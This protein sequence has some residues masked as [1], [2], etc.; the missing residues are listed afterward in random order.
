[1]SKLR[2]TKSK[3]NI[4]YMVLADLQHVLQSAEREQ[5]MLLAEKQRD[6]SFRS[7]GDVSGDKY[8]INDERD[9][10]MVEKRL[11]FLFQCDLLPGLQGKVLEAK[12]QRDFF[13]P[14]V[15]AQHWKVGAWVLTMLLNGGML[16][17]ITLFALRQSTA[18]QSAWFQSF[19]IWLVSEVF[20]VSTMSMMATHV[21]IPSL[22]MGDV[23]RLKTKIVEQIN[24][25][26][27]KLRT[28][29]DDSMDS[30]GNALEGNGFNAAKYLYVSHRLASMYPQLKVAKVVQSY[31]TVW[32]RQSY[33]VR[34]FTIRRI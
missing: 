6:A 14:R 15:I 34:T 25:F 24:T 2:L 4:K 10:D 1:M 32:P 7:K 18:R 5:A 3:G 8:L 22:V 11:L 26:Q 12:G 33:Q 29:H 16:S 17:Y 19:M 13:R 28:A 9:S 21:V 27:E 20:L 23:R 30:E 31:R